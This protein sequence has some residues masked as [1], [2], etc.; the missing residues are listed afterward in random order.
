[1]A[2]AKAFAAGR[3]L[4]K[5]AASLLAELRPDY[6]YFAE[7]VEGHLS[8]GFGDGDSEFEFGLDLLLEALAASLERR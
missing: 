6:P 7:H 1:M 4:A 5:L 3:D 2:G 8:R